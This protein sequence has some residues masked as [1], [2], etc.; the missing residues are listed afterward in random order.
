[1][2]RNKKNTKKWDGPV[3]KTI[4]SEIA[5]LHP[6]FGFPGYEIYFPGYGI[7]EIKPQSRHPAGPTNMQKGR[8]ARKNDREMTIYEKHFPRK[9]TPPICDSGPARDLWT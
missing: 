1:M 5:Q 7:Y 2:A 6:G 9:N 8:P 3:D 4:Q